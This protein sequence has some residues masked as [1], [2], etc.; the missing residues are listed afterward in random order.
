[1]A[2]YK[3]EDWLRRAYY[4]EGR[5]LSDIADEFGVTIEAVR[6]YME[7]YDLPR[8]RRGAREGEENPG[9]KGG[10][11]TLV[12]E[13][14]GD[15]FE[16][17]RWKANN[18]L[19]KY[20]STECKHDGLSERYKGDGN[21][22][23]GVRGEENATYGQTGEDAPNWQGGSSWRQTAKWLKAKSETLERD[24]GECVHCGISNEEHVE[25]YD[26]GLHTHHIKAV[27]EGGAK[28][29]LD[30]LETIC[31]PCHSDQHNGKPFTQLEPRH[32]ADDKPDDSGGG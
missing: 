9:W 29:D 21:P 4:D 22:Q 17:T 24:G 12:C 30:N 26:H 8:R 32:S 14:C 18:D 13:S 2:G 27:S 10:D 19:A 25:Q 20:C 28:F 16:T 11:V 7:K 23:H 1:M 3:D 5:A 31:A 15:E 6:Y